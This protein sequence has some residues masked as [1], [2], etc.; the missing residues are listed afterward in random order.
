M[1]FADYEY[2]DGVGYF[3]I[4]DDSGPYWLDQSGVATLMISRPSL[5][6]IS[7]SQAYEYRD[8]A[9]WFHKATGAGPYIA[10]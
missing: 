4:L 2:R 8:S 5:A 10:S 9:G 3:H 7:S 1:A 6:G